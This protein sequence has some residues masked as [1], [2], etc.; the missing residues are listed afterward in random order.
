MSNF[1]REQ[2]LSIISLQEEL[3][4]QQEDYENAYGD[5]DSNDPPLFR[6]E[7]VLR[8][9][10]NISG[11]QLVEDDLVSESGHDDSELVQEESLSE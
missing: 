10:Q 4:R 3:Q 8:I 9:P 5:V 6:V 1:Y 2:Q 7:R 11:N